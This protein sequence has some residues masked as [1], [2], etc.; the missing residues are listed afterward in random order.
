MRLYLTL[1]V[2]FAWCSVLAQNKLLVQRIDNGHIRTIKKGK[3]IGINSLIGTTLSKDDHFGAAYKIIT[4]TD[5]TVTLQRSSG[6]NGD[7]LITY[8][9][10]DIISIRYR[11]DNNYVGTGPLPLLV[12]GFLIASPFAGIEKHKHYNW[13]SAVGVFSAGVAFSAITYL[14]SLRTKEHSYKILR[15][16]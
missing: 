16:A 12:V 9:Y 6:F 11:A 14:L 4:L 7:K 15:R 5:S 3:Y 13:G 2:V 10:K 1:L 8:D